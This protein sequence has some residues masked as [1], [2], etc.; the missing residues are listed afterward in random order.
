M[1]VQFHAMWS[2]YTDAQRLAVLDKMAAAG[3]KWV[4]ID[5]GWASFQES[6]PGS[7]SQ[8]Y[9]DRADFVIDAARARGINVLGTLWYTPDWANGGRGRAVPP[10]DASQYGS[11]AGWVAGHFKGRVAAWEIWNEPNLPDFFDGTPAQYVELLKAAYAPIKAA[12]PAAK[13]VFGGPAHNDTEWLAKAYAAGAKGHFD[14]MSTHPYQGVAD[15]PPETPDDG[16]KWMLT[17]V[18]EV[19]ELMVRQGDGDKPIWFTEFG[20][21]SHA[22]WDGVA[23]WDRGVTEQQQGDYLVRTLKLAGSD[24]PYVTNVFWY[25]D[26]NRDSGNIRNDNYGLL[27]RDLSPKPAYTMLKDFLV[28]SGQ[29]T[30]TPTASPV[31]TA[32]PSPSP[33]ATVAPSP[34]P[35]P[36]VSPSPTA[37]TTEEDCSS[38]RSDRKRRRCL[39]QLS[40]S[41]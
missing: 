28:G 24:F 34:S 16:T 19:H 7:Y 23:N 17:H 36:P 5:L 38:I 15:L 26:R 22:N 25:N 14:V 30:T 39:R 10:N 1:G 4:R 6:G 37:G 35:T 13:V 11:F 33:T 20:W 21:S 32:S 9:V 2:D 8:W 27:Y 29:T 18:A 31:P 12:D 41:S 40:R 3:V